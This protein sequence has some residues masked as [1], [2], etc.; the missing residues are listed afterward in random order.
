MFF[1]CQKLNC[2][3]T[4]VEEPEIPDLAGIDVEAGLNRVVGNKT[5]YRSILMQF[6]DGSEH[7]ISDLN[8]AL[9]NG[10]IETATRIAH[11]L[12]GVAG[13]I[14]ASSLQVLAACLESELRRGKS[15]GLE[16]QI[17]DVEE[18]LARLVL[19]LSVLDEDEEVSVSGDDEID[20]GIATPLLAKL[21][22]L[23]EDD[24]SEASEVL[25]ELNACLKG[26]SVQAELKQLTK[27][28]DQFDY[29]EALK[30]LKHLMKTLNLSQT[31]S[32]DD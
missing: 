6:R 12:K 31:D 24:D 30:I 21:K 23:L 20:F 15:S 32:G 7:T 19:T 1:L 13:N 9:N 4:A 2:R 29:E 8:V 10:D 16:R 28:V 11:T 3:E 26:K 5:L 27:T 22:A 25:Y 14:G 17:K 18:Q